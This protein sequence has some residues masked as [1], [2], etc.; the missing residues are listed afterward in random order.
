MRSRSRVSCC[1]PGLTALAL[2]A[3]AAPAWASTAT[4]GLPWEDTITTIWNSLRGPV[5]STAIMAAMAIAGAGYALA[6]EHHPILRRGL[7]IAFG[8]A[9]VFGI[10]TIL[11]TFGWS[12]ATF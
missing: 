1:W 10:P 5:A 6:P 7:A 2:L 9:I 12:G 8:G 3:L 4:T 11:A